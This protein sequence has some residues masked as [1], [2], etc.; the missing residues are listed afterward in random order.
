M[1]VT[2]STK[3]NTK[4]TYISSLLIIYIVTAKSDRFNNISFT[5]NNLQRISRSGHFSNV[6]GHTNLTS[7]NLLILKGL[8]E[9]DRAVTL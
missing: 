2:P 9:L 7:C 3:T 4:Q 8:S 6:T 5:I 1:S